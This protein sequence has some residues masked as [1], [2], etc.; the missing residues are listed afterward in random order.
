MSKNNRFL[1]GTGPPFRPLVRP[2]S[3]LRPRGRGAPRGHHVC[4]CAAD[5]KNVPDGTTTFILNPVKRT[6]VHVLPNITGRL[7]KWCAKIV[8]GLLIREDMEKVGEASDGEEIA[9]WID[10][11]WC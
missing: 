11:V 3:A 6:H 2:A 4:V 8:A 9:S 10:V 5:M 7:W 1:R